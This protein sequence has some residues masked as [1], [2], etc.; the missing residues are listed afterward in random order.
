MAK[1]EYY[2]ENEKYKTGIKYFKEAIEINAADP[3][4]NY[5]LGRCYL[6]EKQYK[7][8]LKHLKT[9]AES[10]QDNANFQFW[11]GVAYAANNQPKL[12][13]I[14]Y[15]KTLS[16]DKKHTQ[17]LCYLGHNQFDNG[18]LTT[19][20]A[21][22]N[23]ALT[24][25]PSN[26]QVLYN[27]ALVLGKLGRTPE[28]IIAWKIYLANYPAGG[29]TR[30]S[31]ER[32]NALGDFEYRN[33][34]IGKRTVTLEKILFQ[35][36]T[37]VLSESSFPS[38]DLIGHILTNNQKIRLHII[39]Y[40]KNNKRLAEAR[41]KSIKKYLIKKFPKIEKSRLKVSWFDVPTKIKVG[42]KI[43]AE[44]DAISFITVK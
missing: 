19:A 37:A 16:L 40:Q 24:M 5:Y 26:A 44:D 30:K 27:R 13:R 39:A 32:L 18:E 42:K 12:E 36:F 3:E 1:G 15:I 25:S 11:L 22:Y 31:V 2:L 28:E 20:L 9:A 33:Y 17:A 35:P 34:L 38:L 23:K 7:L 10:A 21:T 29:F 43:L 14:S 6:A 4:V 41:S 8:G